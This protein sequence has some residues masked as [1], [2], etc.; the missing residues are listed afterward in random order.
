M[1]AFILVC[2]AALCLSAC[3]HSAALEPGARYVNL[4]SSF[5]AGAGTGAAPPGSPPRCYQST[6]NYAH[7]L[8]A[9]LNL[10]L[11][12]VS[13]AGATSANVL[14]PWRELPAQIDAVTSD[15]R[16][17]T[18]TIGGNDI[19]Y[20]GN[21]TAASCAPGES[22]RVAGLTLPCPP[23]F[24]VTEEAYAGLERNLREIA[25]QVHERAPHA[26]L[27]FIQYVTLV[28]DVQCPQS[29]FTETEAAELRAVAARLFDIT[30]R[31]AAESGA[32]VLPMDE[33]SRHHTPCD[34]DPWSVGLPSDYQE[35][36]GAPWHPNRRGMGVIADRLA[37]MPAR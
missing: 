5:A 1:K 32:Q 4:G 16:L 21:L 3:A 36:M 15:T 31:A 6:V 34:A 35:A 19:A 37:A 18:I 22:I 29:R 23:P 12:D 2:A 11:D 20:V 33:I 14:A 13:C 27:V 30:A 7:L 8:A 17:V 25:R 26:R 24:A 10:A 28:P 9:R